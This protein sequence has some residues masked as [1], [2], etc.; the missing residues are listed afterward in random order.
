MAP[1]PIYG[2]VSD[3]VAWVNVAPVEFHAGESVQIEV[4]VRNPT[5]YPIVVGFPTGC[6]SFVVKDAS[7]TT[8]APSPLCIGIGPPRE[9]A[10]GEETVVPFAWDGDRLPPGEYQV[11]S[12]G[13]PPAATPVPIRILA[14]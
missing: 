6:I 14:P 11:G 1:E 12:H 4:G 3:L 7:G 10:P 13:V 5:P 8:V 2:S 9:M